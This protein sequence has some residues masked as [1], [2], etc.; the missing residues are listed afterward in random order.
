MLTSFLVRLF[1]RDSENTASPAVRYAYG[2]L[3]GFTGL[4]CNLLL[5][6][7][8][9]M[10]GFLTGSLAI[11]ADAFNNLSDAGSGIVTLVGFK[12]SNMPPDDNH[13]FGHGRIEY[14]STMGV[15]VLI[16][17]AGFELASSA[18]DKIRHPVQAQF[19]WITF[20]ILIA[21]IGI[22][23]WMALFSRQ[24]G[25]RIQSK[26]LLAAAV[27][28][29]NDVLCTGLVLV[30]AL[31]SHFTNWIIDGYI[32][33]AVA[34]FVMW[35]GFSIIKET[36]SP[37]LGQAPDP[38]LVENIRQTV[39]SH[40]GVVGIHD[41]IIHDYGPGR[42]IVSLHAEVP[43]DQSV[44]TSHDLI[45]NIET[46][47]TEAYHLVCCIHMDPV[48]TE[49][50]ETR[51]LKAQMCA[52]LRRIDPA[53]S[54]HDFRVV[55]GDTHTNVLFD[56]VVPHQYPQREGLE[57]RIR[58]DIHRLDPKLNGVIKVENSFV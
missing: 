1:V 57:Q 37:L 27:D 53:L 32:G 30:S 11:M 58:E 39:L 31:I 26:S 33:L 34:L 14:L 17:L 13:P 48:D 6:A 54:M 45:D 23:L 46:E 15:A 35:S 4:V 55:P 47:L 52:L 9:I 44:I 12:L 22:K 24:I 51:H 50:T 28:S 29:R 36:V 19:T 16:I 3:A 40:P 2:R 5:F 8:K 42:T 49:N 10:V 41:M 7:L 56:V 20:F 43:A 21:A 18:M 25:R 38:E